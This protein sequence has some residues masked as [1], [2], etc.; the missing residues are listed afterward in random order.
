MADYSPTQYAIEITSRLRGLIA[1]YD[2]NQE[3]LALICNVSQSQFSKL[4]RGVRPMSIDQV[5]VV[6]E[7]LGQDF[8]AFMMEIDSFLMTS[9]EYSSPISYVDEQR[10]LPKP[11]TWTNDMLDAWGRSTLARM[12][13]HTEHFKGHVDGDFQVSYE[14][15]SAK[16]LPLVAK[17]GRRKADQP[18]AE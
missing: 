18:Y 10:K 2:I 8:G 13:M 5:A 9:D 16:S 17:R 12:N 15:P 7:A 3:E 14:D 6:L 11:R 4:I 1:R